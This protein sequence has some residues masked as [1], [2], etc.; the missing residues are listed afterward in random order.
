MSNETEVNNEQSRAEAND[1][2]QAPGIA[3]NDF[4]T[5]ASIVSQEIVNKDDSTTDNILQ[6]QST[7]PALLT[8]EHTI[9]QNSDDYV[10]AKFP[11]ADDE[12]SIAF[13]AGTP[14]TKTPLGPAIERRRKKILFLNDKCTNK[15][16]KCTNKENTVPSKANIAAV[17]ISKKRKAVGRPLPTMESRLSKPADD[18]VDVESSKHGDGEQSS[19]AETLITVPVEMHIRTTIS[20]KPQNDDSSED[21]SEGLKISLMNQVKT[22]ME[23]YLLKQKCPANQ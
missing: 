5:S 20:T 12:S 16:N 18:N 11:I 6:P 23:N 17:D 9:H 13:V 2:K 10:E 14:P 19:Q 22:V 21:G 15:E 7:Q 4:Q 3:N 1:C 8:E